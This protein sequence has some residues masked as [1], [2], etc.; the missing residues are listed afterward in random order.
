MLRR[1]T[2]VPL[3]ELP[4]P[5]TGAPMPVVLAAV[6]RLVV[7]YLTT[8]VKPRRIVLE[9]DRALA[10][11]LGPP[12]DEAWIGHPLAKRGLE[13]YGVHE[14]KQSSWIA[15]L[16]KMNRVHSRHVA[17]LFDG[18]RHF[19]FMLKDDTLEVIARSFRLVETT[20]LLAYVGKIARDEA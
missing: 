11:K 15:D 4:D 20:S 12:N 10:H 1:E 2:V 14:V 5:N 13:P 19:I 8:S 9:F 7:S 17:G 18:Y 6:D 3:K 16:E